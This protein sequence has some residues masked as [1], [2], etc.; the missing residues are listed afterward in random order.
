VL[1]LNGHTLQRHSEETQA[2]IALL[3]WSI[4]HLSIQRDRDALPLNVLEQ[5]NTAMLVLLGVGVMVTSHPQG[6]CTQGAASHQVMLY[7]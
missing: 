2:D 3:S 6:T 1:N 4:S 5:A 7:R